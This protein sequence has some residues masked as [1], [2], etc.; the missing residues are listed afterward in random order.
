MRVKKEKKVLFSLIGAV[1]ALGLIPYMAYAVPMMINYQGYL[2]DTNRDPINESVSMTFR[3]YNTADGGNALWTETHANVTITNGIFSVVLGGVTNL[4]ENLFMEELYLGVSVG[5]DS[6]MTPRR[7]LTSAAYAIRAGY[8]DN[9]SSSCGDCLTT[10]VL[11]GNSSRLTSGAYK[12]GVYDELYHSTS[13]NLQDVLDD[14]DEAISNNK[15]W[16]KGGSDAYYSDGNVG[17]GTSNPSEKLEVAGSIKA[18]GTICDNN[19]CIGSGG[20]GSTF[21]S[22]GNPNCPTGTELLYS[23]FGFGNYYGNTGGG[24]EPA[25]IT[26]EN[27]DTGSPGPGTAYADLLYPLRTGNSA[28]MPP[29]IIENRAVRC[30]KCYVESPIFEIWGTSTCPRGWTAAYTG[31][32][33]G[34]YYSHVHPSNRKCVDNVNF[35]Y[36]ILTDNAYAEIWYG[37]VMWNNNDINIYETDRYV[38]CAVCIKE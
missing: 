19:G 5:N 38:K 27:I 11:S 25:C 35:D 28:Q 9:S 26:S 7:K 12:I 16:S 10:E 30:A 17:I 3:L 15:I 13:T 8:V 32:G 34:G 6:E 2:A 18:A 29:G 23:G 21:T 24:V 31:Y 20:A 22:W 14:L 33:M 1:L 4:A 37:T 36:S